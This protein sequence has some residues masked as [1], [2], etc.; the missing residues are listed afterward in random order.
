MPNDHKHTVP[1]YPVVG[2]GAV[3]FFGDKV[4][5]IKRGKPPKEDEWSL[6]GGR[7]EIGE[8]VIDTMVREVFEETSLKVKP[9]PLLDVID[10]IE[11]SNGQI[12]FHYTLI[13]YMAESTSDQ[14]VAASDAKDARFFTLEDALNLPLWSETKRMILLGAEKK[15]LTLP[16]LIP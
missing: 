13:D 3:V 9:G 14:P 8:R 5:L 6:P 1:K 10:Y 15:G 4:L 2:V 11:H 7:Q 12:A 16:P